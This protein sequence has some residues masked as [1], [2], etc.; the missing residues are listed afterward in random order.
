VIELSPFRLVIFDKDG[1]LIDFDAMWSG[2]VETLAARL[3]TATGC[4]LAPGL[5]AGL[6]YDAA[7][8]RTIAGGRLAVTSMADLFRWI[9]GYLKQHGLTD[10]EAEVVLGQAWFTPDPAGTAQPLVDL[11]RLFTALRQRGLKIAIA[12]SD[13]R[14]PTLATLASLGVANLV[15][16]LIAAD[17]GVPLK[18]APDMV[19]TACRATGL[20]P[21]QAIVVGD[22]L[23]E[24][25]MA[26]AAAAGLAVG[27]TSGV[28]S[29]EL[30]AGY[31]DIVI[32]N[33]AQLL[34]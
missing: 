29:A 4:A 15:D 26:R 13:D 11:L 8:R 27:V 28:S 22:A 3:E 1:T 6:G 21:R 23:P 18:P 34:D 12:T 20:E 33:V 10:S 19:W 32:E 25:L 16:A 30:L 7:H 9:L 2:W 14:A 31:A 17:D 5:F 24:L